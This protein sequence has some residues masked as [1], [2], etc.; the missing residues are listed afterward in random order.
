MTA[1]QRIIAVGIFLSVLHAAGFILHSFF[2]RMPDWF[3]I[4]WVVGLFAGV[5]IWGLLRRG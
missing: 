3:L 4:A 5:G 2:S 1:L